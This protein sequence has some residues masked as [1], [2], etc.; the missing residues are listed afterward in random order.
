MNTVELC[1]MHSKLHLFD[2]QEGYVDVEHFSML[3]K[4]DI[5][6]HDANQIEFVQ[7]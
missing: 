4:L 2:T 7:K 1:S 5:Y 3:R 6:A